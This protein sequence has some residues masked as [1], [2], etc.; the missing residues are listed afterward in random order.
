M[1]LRGIPETLV[2]DADEGD[3][4]SDR[5]HPQ[6]DVE[7]DVGRGGGPVDAVVVVQLLN[8]RIR[9]KEKS[10]V[11]SKIHKWKC[12]PHHYQK[13]EGSSKFDAELYFPCQ[14]CHKV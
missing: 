1:Q 14:F 8:L 13:Q 9:D 6:A 11:G 10:L 3:D 4:E 5:D 7:H 2:S 12:S